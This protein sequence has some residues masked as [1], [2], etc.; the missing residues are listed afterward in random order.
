[1]EATEAVLS[2]WGG[3]VMASFVVANETNL[4][5]TL[6][7]VECNENSDQLTLEITIERSQWWWNNWDWE[8]DTGNA[9][10]VVNLTIVKCPDI[11]N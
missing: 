9:I 5:I 7:A 3:R 1:L 2:E 8:N 11:P 6:V 10:G 4:P